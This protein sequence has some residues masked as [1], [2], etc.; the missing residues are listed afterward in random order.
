MAIF[1]I[2]AP[3]IRFASPTFVSATI[4]GLHFGG[5]SKSGTR[6]MSG[7]FPA[8]ALLMAAVQRQKKSL[9]NALAFIQ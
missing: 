4:V 7:G 5:I 1:P 2:S 8:Y 6:L 9:K 3:S